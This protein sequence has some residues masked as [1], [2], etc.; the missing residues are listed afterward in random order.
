MDLAMTAFW[1]LL[2]SFFSCPSPILTGVGSPCRYALCVQ[3]VRVRVTVWNCYWNI[4]LILICRSNYLIVE[5]LTTHPTGSQ[6]ILVIGKYIEKKRFSISAH[7][8]TLRHAIKNTISL[9][10]WI[11]TYIRN[12]SRFEGISDRM[13]EWSAFSKISLNSIKI[14]LVAWA[15]L[16]VRKI[17][18]RD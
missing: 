4:V 18:F 17:L 11:L 16:C 12:Y 13:S 10:V 1:L 7:S 8:I 14:R 2:N 5:I 9:I 15:F 6:F 3:R